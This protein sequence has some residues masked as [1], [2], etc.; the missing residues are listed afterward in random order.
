MGYVATIGMFDGVHCGHQFVL[1]QVAAAAQASSLRSMAITFDHAVRNIPVLTPLD[2]KIRLMI[3][4]GIDRVEMLP[5]TDTLRQMTAREFMQRVL[6]EQLDVQ[7]LLTGYDNRFGHNREEG[8]DDYVRYGH[9]LD[10]DVRCL[11]PAPSDGV[12][13]AVS[14]SL[15]RQQLTAGHVAE[16]ADSL[17]RPYAIVG[18][19]EHGMHI[20]TQLG[21]PTANIRPTDPGQLI[22]ANGVYAVEADVD[23]T[24]FKGM[25]NIGMRPTFDG[26]QQTLEV[27]IFQLHEN[28]YGRSVKVSFLRRLREEQR[29]ATVEELIK[30]L[31]QDAIKAQQ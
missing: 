16:A 11:P 5:F 21:F 14:S 19:V 23:G 20:G 24:V 31:K 28:L 12:S 22:P 9:E 27:H 1:R 18:Q 30:Q 3:A 17:G 25:M 29:F 15:I 26:R 2:E 4:T 10:I 8:F 13:T 7:V 6:K